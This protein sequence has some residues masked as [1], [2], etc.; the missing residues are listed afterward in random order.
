MIDTRKESEQ[1]TR[2]YISMKGYWIK[3]FNERCRQKIFYHTRTFLGKTQDP[4]WA[5]GWD[6]AYDILRNIYFSLSNLLNNGRIMANETILKR[7]MYLCLSITDI[8]VEAGETPEIAIMKN[9][10]KFN[11]LFPGKKNI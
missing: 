1:I 8:H 10:Q 4:R 3:T 9:M 5:L 6:L 2:I 7:L 11:Q